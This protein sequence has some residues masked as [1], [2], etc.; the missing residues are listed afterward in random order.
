MRF[1][2]GFAVFVL[3]AL[4]AP[5]Q[6][7]NA[8]QSRIN[9]LDQRLAKIASGVDDSRWRIQ[10][11][12]NYPYHDNPRAGLG[13]RRLLN[14]LRRGLRQGLYC[15]AGQSSAGRLHPFHEN[16]AVALLK[17]LESPLPK[18]V[19]CVADESY[20]FAMA[21]LPPRPDDLNQGFDKLAPDAPFPALVIDTYRIS[22]F[23]TRKHEAPVYRDFFKMDERQI[24]QHLS[25]KPQRLRGMHR[26]RDRAS[27]LFHEMTHWLGFTHG[28]LEPDVVTLY[29]TCCFNGSDFI[30]NREQ[31]A[32]FRDQ[33]CEILRDAELWDATPYRQ[34][35]LWHY[36]GYNS[37][38]QEMSQAYD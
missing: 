3:M 26:Y 14:D 7:S 17:L 9:A 21:R 37:F 12:T 18:T 24:E 23:V 31:N 6:A 11:C 27:L 25:G 30:R 38:R 15:L 5:S 36:K 1:L 32:R 28:N 33:A 2:A 19:R 20:A 22:G 35:R 16:K 8:L 34:T 13:E 29:E 4:N 10:G